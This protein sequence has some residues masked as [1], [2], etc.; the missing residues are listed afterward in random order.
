M[1]RKIIS[2]ALC[3]A[4][5]MGICTTAGASGPKGSGSTENCVTVVFHADSN[6]TWKFPSDSNEYR[7]IF[8]SFT[9]TFN[10]DRSTA[11]IEG[12]FK[13]EE[14]YGKNFPHSPVRPDYTFLGWF[15]KETDAAEADK[16]KVTEESEVKLPES[17]T[18]IDLYAYWAKNLTVTLNPKNG[19]LPNG[20]L[21]NVTV[22]EKG[23][24]GSLPQPARVGYEFAGWYTA[25]TNGTEVKADTVVNSTENHT[26]Y[27]HWDAKEVTVTFN[28][29]GGSVTNS[30]KEV[31]VGQ[32]YGTLPTPTHGSGDDHAGQTFRG[33]YTAE[34]GGTEVKST[35]VVPATD[36]GITLY[37]HWDNITVTF[38]LGIAGVSMPAN[39]LTRKVSSG[40]AYSRV[41]E[42]TTSVYKD[43]PSPSS[44]QYQFN[45]WYSDANFSGSEVKG[46][47][48]V[49]TT[50]N[51]TLYAKWSS[52]S[53]TVTF[54]PNGGIVSPT[55]QTYTYG[56]KYTN[57]PTPTLANYEFD[58]WFDALNGGNKITE[59]TSVT[60]ANRT[61]Y[62]H[63]TQLGNVRLD[64]NGGT[65][66]SGA[67]TT[68]HADAGGRYPMLPTPSRDGYTFTGWTLELDKADTAVRE[69]GNVGAAVPTVLYA[70]WSAKKYK[71][72][73]DF[74][75]AS[76]G[77]V[78]RDYTFGGKYS[79][80][81]SA[82]RGGYSLVGWF[83]EKDGGSKVTTE[84]T[85]S[86][87]KDHTLYARWGFTIDYNANGG[88]GSMPQ[89]KAVAGT[90]FTLPACSFTPPTGM[91]FSH[92]SIGSEAGL[93]ITEASHTFTAN[94][95]LYAHWK[96]SPLTISAS[97]TTGGS[98][99]PS[100]TVSVDK[101]N[102]QAFRVTVKRGY[103]LTDLIVDGESYG[104]LESYVFRNVDE[105]H[106]IRAVFLPE[107][108]PGY[109][110]CGKD[111]Y[112]PLNRFTDLNPTAWY[113]NAV[114]YCL[115]NVL[116]TGV[117]DRVY[118][119]SS[120][121]D[122]ASLAV[123]L[124]RAAGCP[125]PVGPGALERPYKDVAA[126]DSWFYKGV[127]WATKNEIVTGYGNGYFGPTDLVTREQVAA[128]LWRHAGT[129]KP[130]SNRLPYVDSWRVSD[131]FWDAMCWAT[132]QGIITG[133]GGGVLDP[134]GYAT[135][136]EIA[137]M[138]LNYF[139]D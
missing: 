60:A 68:I 15:S 1:Y 115:D 83:T 52:G 135:R 18:Q 58:G 30:T 19:T 126:T 5:V 133:K 136:V 74:N 49:K 80:M 38:H 104:P 67:H 123:I 57:M 37:A 43:L 117:S 62:A 22:Y 128:I 46:S 95:T 129:P 107:A 66:P 90:A 45:G 96:D 84:T 131:Y 109:L 54:N 101:G 138:M 33:W 132:E 87:A 23:E 61:F 94:T 125:N 112:C 106:T 121:T 73:F 116:L 63:W 86:I 53:Y 75:G 42:G 108:L 27:A 76:G 111:I 124:W 25:E 118:S 11:S 26:L 48:I 29:M 35:T 6:G 71:V 98:I 102:D 13:K 119:L 93:E 105:D 3:L 28:A 114:H 72:T 59:E 12:I 32:T 40:E 36:G 130:I 17:S 70:C 2:L 56:G 113:H 69:N 122:R 9:P 51:H 24:Y 82:H 120:R 77:P 139:G 97:A 134:K 88:A 44:S 16:V 55:T 8:D 10:G 137:Q 103:E 92:W 14:I 31:T 91:A 78:T 100:G 20:T 7:K 4:L 89:S 99:S 85:V 110:G 47:D 127:V 34:F 65:L 21:S 79:S 64:P 50:Q 39:E 41:L 81:P